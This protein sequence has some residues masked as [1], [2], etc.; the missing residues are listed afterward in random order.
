LIVPTL[1]LESYSSKR[2]K[3]AKAVLP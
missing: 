3:T 1:H 2:Q